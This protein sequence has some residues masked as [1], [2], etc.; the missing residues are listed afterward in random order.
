MTAAVAGTEVIWP[1][2][3]VLGASIGTLSG[4]FGV[5]G[6]FLLTPALRILFGIP[7]ITAIGSDLLM[8]TITGGLSACKYKRAGRVDVKLGLLMAAGALPG[9]QLGKWLLDLLDSGAQ[10]FTI[11][12]G[13]FSLLDLVMKSLFLV[14]LTGVGISIARE[15]RGKTDADA[16][17]Q[18]GLSKRLRAIGAGPSIE[19]SD[20]SGSLCIWVPLCLAFAVAVLTGLMGV[21]GGF[22]MLPLLVYVLGVP[23]HTAVG[24]SALYVMFAAGFGATANLLTATPVGAGNWQVGNVDLLLVAF[25]FAGSFVGVQVGVRLAEKFGGAK[26]RRYFALVLA[27]G[28]L[29][30][31][32]ELVLT[33]TGVTGGGGH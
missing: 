18:T 27:A 26:I 31:I 23:T 33:I 19:L 24:T 17:V 13:E 25:L 21:G 8:I 9:V 30:I 12:H 4:L 14:L 16:E 11:A 20:G 5:G 3:I 2:I 6:A 1:L 7:F 29:M 22:I 28:S 32:S 15:S 10:T